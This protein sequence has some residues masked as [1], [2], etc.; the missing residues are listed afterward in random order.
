MLGLL[1]YDYLGH[2]E[3]RIFALLRLAG[4][5]GRRAARRAAPAPTRSR[6]RTWSGVSMLEPRRQSR[7][8][9]PAASRRGLRLG[10]ARSSSADLLLQVFE[11]SGARLRRSAVERRAPASACSTYWDA[12][13]PPRR[14][15]ARSCCRSGPG[16]GRGVGDRASP[17]STWC[18]RRSRQRARRATAPEGIALFPR[19]KGE[20]AARSCWREGRRPHGRREDRGRGG[21]SRGGTTPVGRR[22]GSGTPGSRTSSR[23]P[24]APAST[25]IPP[26]PFVVLGSPQSSRLEIAKAHAELGIGVELGEP[27]MHIDTGRGRGVGGDRPRQGRRL[28][29]E[30]AR[31]RA[32]ADWTSAPGSVVDRPRAC[33]STEPRR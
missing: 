11:R 32:A 31:R 12:T 22:A 23:S 15:I 7:S 16:H 6:S 14:R 5:L 33:A 26:T 8:R 25:C 21:W 20:V 29:A 24:R 10:H 4:M 3:P 30:A 28:P 17:S 9:T 2:Y 13:L 18:S 19:F 27:Q 1:V